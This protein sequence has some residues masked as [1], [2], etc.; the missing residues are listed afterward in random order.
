MKV[1]E[2]LI[3]ESWNPGAV[4]RVEV[5]KDKDWV[6]I[7][8]QPAAPAPEELRIIRCVPQKLLDFA[9]DAVRIHLDTAAVFDEWNEIAAVQVAGLPVEAPPPP[10][11]TTSAAAPP[12][13]PPP[14]MTLPPPRPKSSPAAAAPKAAPVDLM[15]EILTTAGRAGLRSVKAPHA[16]QK[17]K[18]KA[19]AGSIA[20]VL[21]KRFEAM[22]GVGKYEDLGKDDDWEAVTGDAKWDD[23]DDWV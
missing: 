11:K 2:V 15:T 13:P 16:S 8:S 17:E 6:T 14:M 22:H 12:P 23:D 4:C 9:T 21:L 1:R 3:L 7:W 20:E 10:P 18:P 5:R 19:E